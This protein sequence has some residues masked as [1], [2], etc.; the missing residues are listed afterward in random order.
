M[1]VKEHLEFYGKL[2]GNMGR[3]ELK[4][5][6]ADMMTKVGLNQYSND[7]VSALS[8]GL[9]RRLEVAIAF[10]C[11]SKTVILDEP[12]SGVDPYNRMKIWDIILEFRKSRTIL[13]TTHYLEEADVLSDRIAIIHQGH[14]QCCGSSLFLKNKFGSG[15]ILTVDKKIHSP[16]QNSVQQTKKEIMEARNKS[17][18]N[19]LHFI[20]K[21]IT[22]AT[23]TRQI[24][25][26]LNFT[27][28]YS[29]KT[30]FESF[31]I[32]LEKNKSALDIASYGISDTTLE[33]IFLMLTTRD[34]HGDLVTPVT[35][36][37]VETIS[38]TPNLSASFDSDKD[39]GVAVE[40]SGDL[41]KNSSKSQSYFKRI[42]SSSS[43]LNTSMESM[44]QA[45]LTQYEK[46]I[47]YSKRKGRQLYTQQFIALILKRFHHNRRNLRVLLTNILL[48]VLFVV[49][50]MA[51]TLIK[52]KLTDQVS[53]ELTPSMYN[54]SSYFMTFQNT[55]NNTVLEYGANNLISSFTKACQLTKTCPIANTNPECPLVYQLAYQDQLTPALLSSSLQITPTL[56]NC[57]I[58]AYLMDTHTANID[59]RFGG[60]TYADNIISNDQFPNQSKVIVWFENQA[61][62][63]MPAF[64]HQFYAQYT[65]CIQTTSSGNCQLVSDTP[66]KP[67]YRIYNHPIS[68][69]DER[70][71]VD[72]IIQKISDIGIS[73]TILCAY[74]FV[75]AGFAM[76]IVRER[77]TQEKRLQYVCGVKPF[78][79]WF[80]SFF[81]DI[82]YFSLI[83]LITLAFVFMFGQTAYTASVRNFTALTLLLFMFGFSSLP[84][85]YLFSR[86]FKDTGSAYMI[87][88][89]FT[90]FSGVATCVAVFLLSFIV[91]QKPD[92]KMLHE[93][94]EVFSMIFPSYC[95]GSGL[96]EIT[97]NQIMTDTYAMFGINNLYKDPFSMEMLGKKYLALTLMGIVS[98]IIIAIMET[99]ID[100]FPCCKPTIEPSNDEKVEDI[101]VN[102]ERERVQNNEVIYSLDSFIFLTH[103]NLF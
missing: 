61:Y 13:L 8:G 70:I 36:T 37:K 57:S 63:S 74:A 48:P 25:N 41:T 58:E 59:K 52:P 50:S 12:T 75:P 43:G 65:K 34:E 2:K 21:R 14:L 24:N 45:Q 60:L 49:L 85:T 54:P 87:I 47:L 3:K 39:S 32:A 73:L 30:N 76:Y 1:T 97:K 92:L 10:V 29:N 93:F 40:L 82:L 80:A 68:L 86:F 6:I 9:R 7:Y 33:E 91:E 28:P 19:I 72:T 81:W 31:F 102:R 77:I 66:I 26:T 38:M 46:P 56:Q 17:I 51:F 27:L 22:D 42:F 5:D 18:E 67:L 79:Y 71:S 78:V 96:I 101:D 98:F 55:N 44:S 35:Q 84:M 11:G 4:R 83:I 15:Y 64:L 62:H 89:C 90:L 88:F 23:L 100:F 20:Q 94:L 16:S 103:M 69:S 53:L 99:K 95:L